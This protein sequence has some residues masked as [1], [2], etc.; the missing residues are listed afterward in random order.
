MDYEDS[1]NYL[2]H[3]LNYQQTISTRKLN[4]LLINM[5]VSLEGNSRHSEIEFLKGEIKKL[6]RTNRRYKR[7]LNFY[8]SDGIYK[9]V[10]KRKRIDRDKGGKAKRALEDKEIW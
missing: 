2:W 9:Q 8:S 7:A 4:K 1:K 6:S 5:N 3:A 10:G